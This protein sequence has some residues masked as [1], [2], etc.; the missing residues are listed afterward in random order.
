M[1]TRRKIETLEMEEGDLDDLVR[2]VN[3]GVNDDSA[4]DVSLSS[5][6]PQLPSIPSV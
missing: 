1:D 3:E 2:M 6:L 5:P 4:A